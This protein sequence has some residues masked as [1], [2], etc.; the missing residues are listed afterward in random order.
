MNEAENNTKNNVNISGEPT[1]YTV[2]N[3][4]GGDTSKVKAT[5][6][7]KKSAE[8]T[9]YTGNNDVAE[10]NDIKIGAD[11]AKNIADPIE[12]E[13]DSSDRSSKS[14]LFQESENDKYS[15]SAALLRKTAKEA[16]TFK[17]ADIVSSVVKKVFSVIWLIF[18]SVLISSVIWLY[19]LMIDNN[20]YSKTFMV[21]VKVK[22]ADVLYNDSQYK[23]Y[24]DSSFKVA[25]ELKGQRS[26]MY[27]MK[28][29]N[30]A[31]YIEIYVDASGITDTGISILDVQTALLKTDLDIS[32]TSVEPKTISLMADY[33]TEKTLDIRNN[34]EYVLNSPMYEKYTADVM[35][36]NYN[37]SIRGPASVVGKI[38]YA[39]AAT[40]LGSVSESRNI[41]RVPINFADAAGNEINSQ[42]ISGNLSFV[43]VKLII[44]TERKIPISIKCT[45]NAKGFEASTDTVSLLFKGD[46]KVLDGIGEMFV[47]DSADITEDTIDSPTTINYYLFKFRLP[48]GVELARDNPSKI[49]VRFTRKSEPETDEKN[50]SGA[51]S[52]LMTPQDTVSESGSGK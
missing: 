4:Y 22:N 6:N 16:S 42:Y 26:L 41:D 13:L 18:V 8:S 10:N 45:S 43:N 15:V 27:D 37:I 31:D 24:T 5:I 23:I 11:D 1:E 48:T 51:D 33:E 12:F 30:I 49:K 20:D 7:L 9:P 34:V 25:V 39:Y 50:E 40:N 36:D 28:S 52:S 47:I 21:D 35:L 14:E 19:V 29:E 46:P 3:E 32:V 17:R 38:S 44:T 2:K